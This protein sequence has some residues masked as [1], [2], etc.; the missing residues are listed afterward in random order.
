[1]LRDVMYFQDSIQQTL[2]MEWSIGFVNIYLAMLCNLDSIFDG[3]TQFLFSDSHLLGG[4]LP[5]LA[6]TDV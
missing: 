1:M 3:F 4:G 6:L 2:S 5:A